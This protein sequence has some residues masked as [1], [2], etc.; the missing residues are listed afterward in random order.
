MEV[1]LRGVNG[2]VSLRLD[3][4][5]GD[6]TYLSLILSLSLVLALVDAVGDMYR[7]TVK[8]GQ[9]RR[10]SVSLKFELNG[11]WL[12]PVVG[13]KYLVRRLREL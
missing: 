13:L 11:D 3:C 2:N 8:V 9:L 6:E 7:G 5:L 10:L 1:P 4:V 12:P